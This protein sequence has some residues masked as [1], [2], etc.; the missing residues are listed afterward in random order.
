MKKILR[1]G[2]AALMS[3]I[4]AALMLAAAG[5]AEEPSSRED[6]IEYAHPY[7]S[8]PTELPVVNGPEAMPPAE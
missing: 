7:A 8:G 2:M 6:D 3:L 5:C 1:A 4:A